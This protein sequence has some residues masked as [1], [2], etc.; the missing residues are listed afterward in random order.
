MRWRKNDRGWL[1]A[2]D[3][4]SKIVLR[5]VTEGDR[6]KR[7]APTANVPDSS[8]AWV[9]SG[10]WVSLEHRGEGRAKAMLRSAARQLV[11]RHEQVWL[12]LITDNYRHPVGRANDDARGAWE[13]FLADLPTATVQDGFVLLNDSLDLGD[14]S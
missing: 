9:L 2:G 5:P 14:P 6:L 13:S 10:L 1:R 4:R 8:D 3:G 12:G 7:L 11:M